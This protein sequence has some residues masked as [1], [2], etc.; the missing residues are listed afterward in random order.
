MIVEAVKLDVTQ[1]TVQYELLRSQVIGLAGNAAPGDTAADQ[2]RGVGLALLLSK[3][4]PGWIEIVETVLRAT[5]APRAADAPEPAPHEGSLQ[6]SA[7][8]MWVA[9]VRHE[10]T[11]LLANLVLSTR[12][13][14]HQL[15]REGYRSW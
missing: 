6:S 3:G 12:P 7:T 4:M 15:S 14:V 8:A 5:L 13:A 11:T 1:Y 10:V 9:S 2:R